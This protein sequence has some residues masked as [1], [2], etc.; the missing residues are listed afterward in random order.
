M[1]SRVRRQ[2][3]RLAPPLAIVIGLL[4]IWELITRLAGVPEWLL[5]APSVI[6]AAFIE[7]APLLGPH[8]ARTASEAAL[9]Y[10]L[11]L[12]GALVLAIAIDQWGVARRAIYPLL[13]T[14]QTI[15]IFALAPLLAIWF[16]FGLL[17]KVLVVA[18]VCFFPVVV[19]LAA[20]LRGAN[21]EM[22]DL[23]RA[24]GGGRRQ[25]FMKVRFPAS[26]PSLLAG[27]KIAATYSVIGAVIAEWL[28]A[29]QGL[30]LYL[31]RSASS[32]KTDHV[33]AA[34]AVI[35]ALSIGLF[36]AVDLL[37]RVIAPWSYAPEE[38][39]E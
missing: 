33:F 34:I 27:M 19:S 22:E 10:G 12:S 32:F 35:T 11:A 29:S 9:G 30:G 13:V 17:P 1:S 8:V 4:A 38:V 14:S 3:G 39:S 20:G 6:A 21:V 15:P 25:I 37:G 7:A 2:A 26:I 5:P 36:V 24:M 16:G 23:V 18:L 31:Q 28:G